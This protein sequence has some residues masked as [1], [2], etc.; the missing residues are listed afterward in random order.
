MEEDYV[1]ERLKTRTTLRAL[2]LL[3]RTRH[4]LRVVLRQRMKFHSSL[5]GSPAEG[6]TT[7]HRFT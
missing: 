3:D 1:I 2:L 7:F 6:K 5:K 4:V